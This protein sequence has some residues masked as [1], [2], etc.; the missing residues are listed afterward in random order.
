MLAREY[1]FVMMFGSRDHS[2]FEP[3]WTGNDRRM[4][5]SIKVVGVVMLIA[6]QYRDTAQHSIHLK[7]PCD[8]KI[9]SY[10]SLDFKTV[11]TKH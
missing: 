1:L 5:V 9:N 3:T 11:L 6:L 4:L 10:F 7:C 8:Q 2:V